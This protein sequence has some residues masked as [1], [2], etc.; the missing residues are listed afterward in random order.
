MKKTLEAVEDAPVRKKRYPPVMLNT[1]LR[2]GGSVALVC[3]NF[4]DCGRTARF[5]EESRLRSTAYCD[6]CEVMHRVRP[7]LKAFGDGEFGVGGEFSDATDFL[8]DVPKLLV[9][10]AQTQETRAIAFPAERRTA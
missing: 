5:V 10:I 4:W 7:I 3:S 6:E 8:L 1:G 9:L 2:V